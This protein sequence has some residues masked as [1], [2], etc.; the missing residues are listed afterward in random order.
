MVPVPCS[1]ASRFGTASLAGFRETWRLSSRQ[2]SNDEATAEASMARNQVTTGSLLYT[3]DTMNKDENFFKPILR[4]CVWDRKS[5]SKGAN[6]WPSAQVELAYLKDIE[7]TSDIIIKLQKAIPKLSFSPLGVSLSRDV[8]DV[9]CNYNKKGY[10]VYMRNGIQAITYA[11]CHVSNDMLTELILLSFR[12]LQ[13]EMMLPFD[14][15]GWKERYE[16]NLNDECPKDMWE[17]KHLS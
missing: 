8:S 9:K 7:Q 13:N 2:T 6:S 14:K 17:W 11:S 4:Y 5:D 16:F 3:D 15:S 1:R 10:E 12:K